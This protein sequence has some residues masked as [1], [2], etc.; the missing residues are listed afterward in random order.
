MLIYIIE[1]II[2]FINRILEELRL[3]PLKINQF[4][5][6]SFTLLIEITKSPECDIRHIS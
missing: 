1:F 5:A 4:E 3:K 6:I 2:I